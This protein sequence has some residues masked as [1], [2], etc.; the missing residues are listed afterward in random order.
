MQTLGTRTHMTKWLIDCLVMVFTEGNMRWKTLKKGCICKIEADLLE[1]ATEP[2]RES[3]FNHLSRS[4]LLGRFNLILLQIDEKQQK[5][6]LHLK[7]FVVY[8]CS[9]TL[10]K[11]TEHIVSQ[12]VVVTSWGSNRQS[13]PKVLLYGW[14]KYDKS[15]ASKC[16]NKWQNY[17][18]FRL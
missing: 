15:V 13:I 16:K 3:M 10:S 7:S 6:F 18:T 11:T 4:F 2:P 14:Q 8:L 5:L 17:I 9:F 1:A 12:R